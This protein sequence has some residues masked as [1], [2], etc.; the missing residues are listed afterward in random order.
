MMICIW[1]PVKTN[2][3]LGMHATLGV[4]YMSVAALGII[5]YQIAA[6][7]GISVRRNLPGI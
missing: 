6:G 3:M 1:K 2:G 7:D 5:L 4:L